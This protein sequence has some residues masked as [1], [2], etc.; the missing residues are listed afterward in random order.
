M[1]KS[2]VPSVAERV[3]ECMKILY[4]SSAQEQ[5]S[6]AVKRAMAESQ[7]YESFLLGIL[8][9]ECEVRANNRI[10][11]F[12]KASHLPEG[13][14]F[15]NFKMSR[16][17]PKIAQQVQTLRIGAFVDHRENILAF[18]KPGS[19]KTHLLC[20]LG[21][22]LV[23]QG[24]AVFFAPACLLVQEMLLAKRDLRLP[25]FLRKLAKF[26]ALIIDDL[27]YVQQNREEMEVLFTLLAERY[28]RGTVML[29]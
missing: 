2:K 6:E 18:G 22:E 26:E 21:H 3:M 27:G 4:L 13:K 11:R 17:P 8:E 10:E 7:S 12:L 15:E 23:R 16:L 28:E 5:F 20:A 9:Q 25:K 19:G 1:Q 24:R 14:T 29:T